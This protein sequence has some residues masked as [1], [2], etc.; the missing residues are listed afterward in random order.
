MVDFSGQ[1]Y[2]GVKVLDIDSDMATQRLDNFLISF[3]KGVPKSKVYQI[4]R[5]GEVRVNK[6]RKNASY[7][8]KAG[9][10]VR[11]PPV[12][13]KAKDSPASRFPSDSL[14][15]V[16][17]WV[18]FEDGGL[19][20]VN[21]PSGIAVHG[22]SGLSFGLIE[23]LRGVYP[24]H[25][26]LELVHRIDKETSGVILVAK[27]RSVLRLIQ[28]QLRKKELN[29]KYLAVLS[30]TLPKKKVRVTR[31]L[32][33]NQLSSGERIVKIDDEH[34]KDSITDFRKLSMLSEGYCFVEAMPV[35]GRTHQI[36]VHAQYLGCPIL[37]DKKYGC[38]Q[39]VA[40]K[41]KGATQLMLH[42][43]A[44]ELKYNGERVSFIAPLPLRFQLL[45]GDLAKKYL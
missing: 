12:R 35:T 25:Q 24:K 20:V 16:K 39:S 6:C 38:L 26:Y 34:G 23:L 21:K 8:L 15:N 44:I 11:V 45:L 37:N 32:L 33:K 10:Q 41:V 28:E 17:S 36:R 40:S 14:K 7:R 5:K 2:T 18:I 42:A 3:L 29:K 1:T 19:L 43:A 31:G 13:L 30:A 27:K 4:I 9:D 22:G